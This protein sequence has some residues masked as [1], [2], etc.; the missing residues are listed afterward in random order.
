MHMEV[1]LYIVMCFMYV[2]L[3]TIFRFELLVTLVARVQRDVKGIR[4]PWSRPEIHCYVNVQIIFRPEHLLTLVAVGCQGIATEM[5]ST[6]FQTL[7]L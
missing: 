5:D 1:I 4:P 2:N 6:L 7:Y 3:Q